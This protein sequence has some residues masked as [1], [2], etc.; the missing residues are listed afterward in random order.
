MMRKTR[1]DEKRNTAKTQYVV[2]VKGK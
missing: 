1:R 2:D